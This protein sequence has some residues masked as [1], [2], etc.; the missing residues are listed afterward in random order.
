[1]SAMSNLPLSSASSGGVLMPTPYQPIASFSL[2]PS[3]QSIEAGKGQSL[4]AGSFD[5]K[6]HRPAI[7]EFAIGSPGY[8]GNGAKSSRI[9]LPD[10]LASKAPSSASRSSR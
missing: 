6:R 2:S 8:D 3:G 7:A 1:M 4:S 5:I 10:G 9:Y